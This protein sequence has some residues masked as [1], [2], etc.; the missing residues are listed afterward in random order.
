[1]TCL[2]SHVDE[3]PGLPNGDH[4]C[5]GADWL[6]YIQTTYDRLILTILRVL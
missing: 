6:V 1:M 3:T 2:D 5:P 4:G